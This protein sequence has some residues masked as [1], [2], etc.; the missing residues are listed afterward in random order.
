MANELYQSSETYSRKAPSKLNAGELTMLA[1]LSN[2]PNV[3]DP[4]KNRVL[5]LE[6][7]HIVVQNMVDNRV[8][9]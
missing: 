1:G 7:Q 5:A 8:I 6:M 2:S 4:Y 3:Y 9:S